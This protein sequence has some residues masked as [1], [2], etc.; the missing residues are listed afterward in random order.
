VEQAPDARNVCGNVVLRRDVRVDL[1]F[2]RKSLSEP[3]AKRPSGTRDISELKARLGLSND[4][5]RRP[6]GLGGVVSPP[7]GAPNLPPPPGAPAPA[8]DPLAPASPSA[9]MPAARSYA[10]EPVYDSTPV[11]NLEK[12]SMGA[13]LAKLA[14]IALIPL[15]LGVAIGSI[16]SSAKVY[17]ATIADAGKIL[18]DVQAVSGALVATQQTFE[19]ARARAEAAGRPKGYLRND[20][21]L[22]AELKKLP[23][24]EPN[25]KI[26]Y[27]S[28]LYE[29]PSEVVGEVLAFYHGVGNLQALL[30]RHIEITSSDASRKALEA[31]QSNWDMLARNS[32]LAAL[33]EM[34]KGNDTV[35][36]VRLVQLGRPVC[37]G[38]SAP[39]DKPCG[40]GVTPTE[41]EF[42]ASYESGWS[43]RNV[44]TVQGEAITG[45]SILPVNIDTKVFTQLVR[46]GEATVSEVAYDA[47]LAHIDEELGKLME[48]RTRVVDKLSVKSRE[49]KRF[50]FFL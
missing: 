41:S 29:L 13:G 45:N 44:A 49:S 43:R 40:D 20:T 15:A 1:S 5:A 34:P 21:E 31:G 30:K 11:A 50:S 22:I 36:T 14:G 25:L 19:R 33:L 4:R 7:G 24:V 47:R 9:Q 18:T 46:G 17:N 3:P 28:Y 39:S 23:V 6:S 42:R 48:L 35:P 26:V 2:G 10:R 8:Y 16:G 27:S 32:P 12:K 37:P 38:S